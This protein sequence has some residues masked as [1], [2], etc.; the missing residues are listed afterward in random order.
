MRG[1]P[2]YEL[3]TS[4]KIGKNFSR[5]PVSTT[6]QAEN[7]KA[8]ALVNSLVGGI[9]IRMPVELIDTP[10]LFPSISL[11][12][13]HIPSNFINFFSLSHSEHALRYAAFHDFIL[14]LPTIQPFDS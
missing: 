1:E 4:S 10:N 13:F 14:F 3:S 2:L 11:Y 8:S 12:S 9:K 5:P 7:S 6:I